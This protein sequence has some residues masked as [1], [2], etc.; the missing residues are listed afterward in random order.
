[1]VYEIFAASLANIR[2]LGGYYCFWQYLVL[3]I[4][5]QCD[6][7]YTLRAWYG[8]MTH[9]VSLISHKARLI[10]SPFNVAPRKHT[11]QTM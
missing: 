8:W 6:I 9:C 1:M 2:I 5:R 10:M 3:S 7:R 11:R 4:E